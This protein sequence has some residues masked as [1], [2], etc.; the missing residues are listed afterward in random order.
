MR[1]LAS[2]S[3]RAE[4]ERIEAQ[5]G[6]PDKPAALSPPLGAALRAGSG[7]SQ[8]A[9]RPE[10]A[11]S[12]APQH[13]KPDPKPRPEDKASVR[14]AGTEARKLMLEDGLAEPHLAAAEPKGFGE[15]DMDM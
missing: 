15:F 3:E 11:R 5:T 4:G 2:V 7:E 6:A 14:P 10:A 13:A 1:V 9:V 12:D 8:K